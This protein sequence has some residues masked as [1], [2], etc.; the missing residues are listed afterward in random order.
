MIVIDHFLNFIENL[1]V[2]TFVDKTKKVNRK[3]AFTNLERVKFST[4]QHWL[5]DTLSSLKLLNPDLE[6]LEEISTFSI[7]KKIEFIRQTHMLNFLGAYSIAKRR[8]DFLEY[9]ISTDEVLRI[10]PQ[11]YNSLGNH[12]L[13]TFKYEL[14]LSYFKK[15]QENI[16]RNTSSW[17]FNIISQADCL[18][19]M[20][21]VEAAIK[22][23]NFLT[24]FSKTN[25][26]YLAIYEQVLGEYKIKCGERTQAFEHLITSKKLFVDLKLN[27]KDYAYCLIYLGV[28]YGLQK[29]NNLALNH[30]LEA[31]KI[32]SFSGQSMLPLLELSYLFKAFN[33]NDSSMDLIFQ[34]YPISY[35]KSN[36]WLGL[37]IPLNKGCTFLFENETLVPI[38]YKEDKSVKRT[39]V[40]DLISKEIKIHGKKTSLSPLQVKLLYLLVS[41]S[42][43]GCF[44]AVLLDSL[45][46]DSIYSEKELDKL[47]KVIQ[48]LCKKGLDIKQKEKSY[49]LMNINKFTI[50]L[51]KI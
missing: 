21:K 46:P 49:K 24:E 44:D 41:S 6:N 39:N 14:A 48:R 33:L 40:I 38:H 7:E 51:Q 25:K 35:V 43:V 42:K 13:Q 45:Y 29:N 28:Y 19:G 5:G 1:V 23:M 15:A 3:R 8:Y 11:Y 2:S 20:N 10:Y 22:K 50:Y 16:T 18:A 27:N 17:F 4:I 36:N 30:L 37:N 31:K 47:K 9:K 26:M 32:L 34:L 12:Y